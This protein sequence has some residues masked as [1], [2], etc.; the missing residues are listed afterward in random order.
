MVRAKIVDHFHD[1]IEYMYSPEG[2]NIINDENLKAI[3]K[4]LNID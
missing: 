4:I 3:K 2:K 1:R